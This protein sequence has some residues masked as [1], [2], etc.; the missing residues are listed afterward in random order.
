M[1][2]F[3]HRMSSLLFIL[4]CSAWWALP[5]E[6]QE[7]NPGL[8]Q[9][10]NE[11]SV[12]LAADIDTVN[13]YNG[14]LTLNVP[15]GQTYEV[16]GSLSYGLQLIY[17]SGA[18]WEEEDKEAGRCQA[19][20]GNPDIDF[21]IYEASKL[22]NAG[23]GW[24][25]SLGR[26]I[27]TGLGFESQL[28][29][30]RWTYIEPN[31]HRRGFY[32]TL[33]NGVGAATDIAYTNDGS[34]MRLRRNVAG[35]Q[36]APG[37]G[38]VCHK[39]EFS[40]GT[41]HEFH[42]VEAANTGFRP[43]YMADRFG[44]WV[45]ID[46]TSSSWT[47]EDIHGRKQIV[48]FEIGA[49]GL[50]RI[51]QIQLTSF[52]DSPSNPGAVY[53][54]QYSPKVLDRH[55]LQHYASGLNCSQPPRYIATSQT[56]PA[57]VTV[58]G[59]DKVV[60]PDQSFYQPTYFLS[61]DVT[62]GRSGG[63]KTLR[64]PTGARLDWEYTDRYGMNVANRVDVAVLKPG[65]RVL[66]VKNKRRYEDNVLTGVWTYEHRFSIY[67]SELDPIAG[68]GNIPCYHKTDVKFFGQEPNSNTPPL[69][70][71]RYFFASAH[72]SWRTYHGMGFSP[73]IPDDPNGTN[74]DGPALSEQTLDSNG[75]V[76]R[77]TY[78]LYDI[79]SPTGHGSLHSR[80]FRLRE[81]IIE[82]HDDLDTSGQ[83][84]WI[85]HTWGYDAANQASNPADYDGLG[86]FRTY[87]FDSNFPQGRNRKE[88]YFKYGVKADGSLTTLADA[89][90]PGDPWVLNTYDEIR[91]TEGSGTTHQAR[92]LFCFDKST[93]FL[94]GRRAL[95]S[96]SAGVGDIIVRFDGSDGNPVRERYY[97]GDFVDPAGD[98][99]CGV[100][101]AAAFDI[102]HSYQ[103]GV[104]AKTEFY[105]GN[106]VLHRPLDMDI[107]IASGLAETRRDISGIA[108]EY[109]YDSMARVTQE[110][111]SGRAFKIHTYRFPTVSQPNRALEH[112]TRLCANGSTQC[113]GS[114]ALK[115][116]LVDYDR[117]G[118]MVTESRRLPG[119][120]GTGSRLVE[121]TFSHDA[122]GRLTDKTDWRD[123]S[124]SGFDFNTQY[125]NYDRFGR[126]GQVV[127]PDGSTTDFS[128]TGD[129]VVERKVGIH[130]TG[131]MQDSTV[132]KYSDAKGRLVLVREPAGTDG[133]MVDTT[134]EYDEGDRLVQICVNDSDQIGTNVCSGGQQRKMDYDDR[135]LLTQEEH[136]ELG[137]AN[138]TSRWI[139]YF[140]DAR[141]NMLVRSLAGN[142]L[143]RNYAYDAAGR[144]V[145]VSLPQ[146][147][148][149]SLGDRLLQE[150]F[151]RRPGTCG[152]LLDQSK[153]HNRVPIPGSEGNDR[154]IVVTETYVYDANDSCRLETYG[155]RASHSEDFRVASFTTDYTYND[156]D[157]V[158]GLEYPD[159]AGPGCSG[160]PSQITY[161]VPYGVLS[162]VGD[163][164]SLTYHPTGQIHTIGHANQV[165]DTYERS[166]NTWKPL[167]RI[168]VSNLA[169]SADWVYGP[170][171]FD[172]NQNIH[173]IETPS[174]NEEF[175]YDLV[176]RLAASTVRSTLG[177]KTQ[178]L[179]YDVYGNLTELDSTDHPNLATPVNGR[180]RL[181]GHGANY[182]VA[183][184]VTALTLDGTSF[185]Y[186]RDGMNLLSRLTGGGVDRSHL[187]TA[188][189]ERFATLDLVSGSEEWTP[190]DLGGRVLSR[191]QRHEGLTF[192][193][194]EDYIH[195]GS[196]QIAAAMPDAQGNETLRHFHLDH[197][198]STRL[199]TDANRQVVTR[200]TYYPFG[201]Y[202]TGAIEGSEA[203]QF[204]GHERDDLGSN[205]AGHLDYMHSRFYTPHLGRFL[206]VD[207][208]AESMDPGSPQSFNRYAYA[209]NN[210]L[211]YRDPDGEAVET[212]WDALNVGIG[213]ASL[214]ANIASGN[215][216]GALLDAAGLV[217][218]VTATAVP[219]VPG[220]A[221]T[222][223]KASRARKLLSA[224]D[225]LAEAGAKGA[226]EVGEALARAGRQ[227]FAAGT[228]VHTERG[229]VP[230]EELAIG[231]RVWSRSESTGD[232][233]LRSIVHRFVTPDQ[234]IYELE[235]RAEDGT[236]ER[237]EVTGEH[238]FWVAEKGWVGA[239][240][241]VLGQRIRGIEG[242]WLR[243]SSGAWSQQ[244]TTV[245][246]LEVDEFHTYFVGTSG[247]W[248]HNQCLPR[249][250]NVAPDWAQKGAHIHVD[251]IE[252]AVRPGKPGEVV[253]RS[254]FSSQRAGDVAAATNRAESALKNPQFVQNLHDAA[255]RAIELLKTGSKMDR[256]RAG[257][258]RFLQHTLKKLG[259]R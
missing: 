84:Y 142:G 119:A 13:L 215:V 208:A 191:F 99:R 144:V 103:A 186:R 15:L 109:V 88:A 69:L 139:R 126:V 10:T 93:G 7:Q 35:C 121:R 14:N 19:G 209:M 202:T 79:E 91:V 4:L 160:T 232:V 45:K 117:L 177:A 207:P 188:G 212:P 153:Q 128:Y 224:G 42:D 65:D 222:V 141:G 44:N 131:G 94:Q 148:G 175:D 6:G 8:A 204:T 104:R 62:G 259:A 77:E 166:A 206:A 245:Y 169:S 132:E 120:D 193:W 56:V 30:D 123:T 154:D 152:G 196:R 68:L 218:D 55:Q 216:G 114:G 179:S 134:Y 149:G 230:I 87:R 57:S 31:G 38:G 106:S 250:S 48:D 220:G 34:Y 147:V 173:R 110:K 178:N 133:A 164:A 231:D 108:T 249:I 61:D 247:A 16:G 170:F 86:H 41:F 20:A 163:V 17:N 127:L 2:R 156:L 70:W 23:L 174:G 33:H 162:S 124:Q 254:V 54:F 225:E 223:I 92:T 185:T 221:G 28:K 22:T 71:D 58:D 118:R 190:R 227:C 90:A 228:L 24:T 75:N 159:C 112:D 115:E 182:D 211:R 40:D 235:L 50:P 97:G 150:F 3:K 72:N 74:Y 161:G 226:D 29:V 52:G 198:G 246:N 73:C 89:P 98:G 155:V 113:S 96:A 111:P 11:D 240:D 64:L 51:D 5:A 168:T 39:I 26:L 203:L 258:L 195:A 82:Y 210:P 46:Y 36:N 60:L 53:D 9:G 122:L 165:V 187:Y 83:P 67:N 76:L 205:D 237:F 181:S 199:I 143:D 105:E 145:Q 49:N 241:L 217:Y 189:G 172:D 135:G 158:V 43:T 200:N 12:Y 27:P 236:A 116:R 239:S 253:F 37:G 257:E 32:S 238:P 234:P 197:L 137:Y 130:T 176:S 213:I 167:H 146:E 201:G 248:V 256:A 184:N 21:T 242:G 85:R 251:G 219:G 157:D 80:N 25:V 66:G 180:N 192:D 18:G 183:G 252:L 171:H 78:V 140:Y 59:L 151:Y 47:I 100:D 229:L 102:R 138:G 194:T 243:V 101:V 1:S 125:K 214:T 136:P 255:G 244:A 233:G 107:D 129:R 63:I 95:K 81:Q